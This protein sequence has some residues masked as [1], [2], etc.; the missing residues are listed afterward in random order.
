MPN[1]SSNTA[2]LMDL[3]LDEGLAEFV[4][5]RRNLGVSWR[6]IASQL[7]EATGVTVTQETVRAWF[8]DETAAAS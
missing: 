8:A 7:Q 5:F 6:R 2:R 3:K 1:L 4:T